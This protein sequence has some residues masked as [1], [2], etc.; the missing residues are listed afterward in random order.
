MTKSMQRRLG[1]RFGRQGLSTPQGLAG[2]QS[3]PQGLAGPQSKSG[4]Q[5]VQPGG[6]GGSGTS[7]AFQL[8]PWL[9]SAAQPFDDGM[10]SHLVRR[11]G[12]GASP[13]EAKALVQAGVHRSV[14]LL[15]IPSRQGLQEYG[16][17]MLPTGEILNLSANLNDQRAQWI[18]EAATTSF[19]L[20]EKM[21]L[22][23]HDHFSVGVT[24]NNG[25]PLM[26]PHVNIFRRHGLGKF[27]DILVEVSRDPA[28]LY[29]LDNRING[30]GSPPRINENYGREIIELY[31]M[32]EGPWY[33]ERDVE[34]AS[35]CLAGWSLSYYNKYSYNAR[36]AIAGRGVK[37]VLGRQ[38]YNS[39][40]AEK[41]GYDL[42]DCLLSQTQTSEYL[43]SKIWTYFVAERPPAS[44]VKERQ[45][46][47]DIVVELGARWKAMDYDLRGLMSVILR[48]NYFF[49]TRSVGRLIKNPME[50]V[51]GVIRNMGTPFVGRYTRLGISLE[52]MGLPLFR[53]TNPSGLA[54]GVAWV[55]SQSYITRA[56]YADEFTQ[57]ST[58]AGIRINWNP[59][60]AMQQYN[61]NTKAEII[62]YY[63]NILVPGTVPVQVR[64]NLSEYMDYYDGT[65]NRR[66]QAYDSLPSSSRHR[67]VKVRGLVYLILTLPEYHAN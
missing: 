36:Y 13:A 29:W 38:I 61:L 9:P 64:S 42:I 43:V 54:D 47:D 21:A 63:L 23:F 41:D 18:H 35:K 28:M 27:R 24:S 66:Y 56:A 17:Q 46:W 30:A 65:P 50:Y 26:L 12:F 57:V 20:R 59:W 55:D 53:Y 7:V 15:L 25:V 37:T 31:T 22:F 19:P 6:S 58:T 40:N 34:Q 32:G 52:E 10:A 3:K 33:T 39:N 14:D 44:D 2:P 49:S 4:V 45:L 5:G 62:D 51:V 60:R 8:S 11:A 16:T 67:L 1:S 48:S